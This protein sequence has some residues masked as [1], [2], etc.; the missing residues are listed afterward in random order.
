MRSAQYPTPAELDAYAKKV[1]NNPLT[2]KIFPNSVKV[3]QR[4]HIRRTV[5]GLDTSGQR[6]SPYPSQ[7]STKAGLLAIVKVPI[8]GIIKDFDGSRTRLLPENM[9]HAPPNVLLQQPPLGLHGNRKMPDADAPPNVTVS[10]S[11][12]PLSMAA[13]LHQNRAADLSSIVHQI[14]QFCQARAGLGSTSV[15]EGQIANPSPISRNLLIHA[16]SRV[17]TH[18]MPTPMPSCIINSVDQAAAA[19][20]AA[21]AT[22]LPPSAMA[23]MNRVP[24]GY[25]NDMK[26]RSWNQH[27]LPHLQQMSDNGLGQ[28]PGKH[29]PR[30]LPGGFPC[31]TLSYPQELCLGQ[32]FSLKPPVDKPT[33]S[34][35]VNGMPGAMPY[36]N[37]HYFQP[38]W[39]NI[40]PT[41][42]SDSSGSLDLA[43]PFHG[44]PSGPSID[45][46]PGT[47]YRAGAGSSN[48]TNVMQTMDYL[49]GDYQQPCFRDQNLGMM[50]KMHRP[51]MSRA[52][53]PTDNRN[54]HHQ[55]PGYR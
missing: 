33:P 43:M 52:P 55:H 48:Q 26:Q 53:E 28:H 25:Q 45:C 46:V 32:P 42:N 18:H 36:T 23:A 54:T 34:P 3:P 44:G 51:P 1:A 9:G 6:Y 31:K 17:S 38:V 22:S 40:L 49:G 39:N 14:N 30:D 11:T 15:C 8:K 7:A 41:P 12:I 21:T 24:A 37:G 47:H 16:S 13:S 4:K 27:L 5:N 19:A 35:P 50:G 2:I 10:T 20:A 29:H